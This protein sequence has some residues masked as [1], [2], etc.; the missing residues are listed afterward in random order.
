MSSNV[1]I[2]SRF[3]PGFRKHI[4]VMRN[5]LAMADDDDFVKTISIDLKQDDIANIPIKDILEQLKK[6]SNKNTKLK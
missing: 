1:T 3:A 5:I 6:C 4:L 2:S